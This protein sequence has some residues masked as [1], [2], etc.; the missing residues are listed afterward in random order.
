MLYKT[1]PESVLLTSVIQILYC[2]STCCLADNQIHHYYLKQ[3]QEI[4]QNRPLLV[5]D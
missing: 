2:H 1:R 3:K 4:K 5:L